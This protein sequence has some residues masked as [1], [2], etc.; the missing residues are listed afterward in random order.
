[1]K[2]YLKVVAVESCP[3]PASL[4]MYHICL[5]SISLLFKNWYHYALQGIATTECE[6]AE[7]TLKKNNQLGSVCDQGI[8]FLA[9]KSQ[10][11]E[12]N[13]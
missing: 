5:S 2:L 6:S 4:R 12:E 3:P 11:L 1:M 7:M 13:L 9:R 10:Y 8:P